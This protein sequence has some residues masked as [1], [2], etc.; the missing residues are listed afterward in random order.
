M[1]QS[2]SVRNKSEEYISKT[3]FLNLKKKFISICKTRL[4]LDTQEVVSILLRFVPFNPS[5]VKT[6]STGLVLGIP[7]EKPRNPLSLLG[8]EQEDRNPN[9]LLLLLSLF[10]GVCICICSFFSFFPYKHITKINKSHISLS[11]SPCFFCF[12]CKTSRSSFVYFCSFLF[13]Y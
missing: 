2:I 5:F 9:P 12:W 1:A 6:D 11:L 7:Q 4:I 10:V 8:E 3:I 13:G